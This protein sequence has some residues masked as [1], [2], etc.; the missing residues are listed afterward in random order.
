MYYMDDDVKQL[1][2]KM[3]SL[4]K[5]DDIV[6]EVSAVL[7]VA[8]S[9]IEELYVKLM[10]SQ[11]ALVDAEQQLAR[12]N[13]KCPYDNDGGSCNNP[14]CWDE[15]LTKRANHAYKAAKDH[16]EKKNLKV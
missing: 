1:V 8:M 16:Y 15:Y 4:W 9:K 12:S 10:V 13:L 11:L 14:I 6:G 5:D 3:D 2:E 7:P